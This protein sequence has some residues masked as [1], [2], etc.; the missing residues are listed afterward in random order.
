MNPETLTPRDQVI[1]PGQVAPDFTLP[2]Q[3][4]HDWTL[5]KELEHGP[6]AL[7]F[8]PMAFTGVCGAEMRC[9][10]SEAAKWK[11]RGVRV[12]GV[13]CDSWPVLKAWS[14]VEGF[15]H[16]LLADMH[17]R[18][19]RAYGLYWPEL[20]VAWRG[21]VIVRR[22]GKVAWSQKREIKQAMNLEEVLAATA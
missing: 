8:F 15:A 20:N 22:D 1:E 16:P 12:V 19:C 11:S 17:R 10:T 18:V 5:S 21:T 2:D 14:N 13:S 3:E 4:K 9:V 7:C 6:V